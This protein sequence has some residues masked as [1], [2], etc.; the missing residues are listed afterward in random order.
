MPDA[1]QIQAREDDPYAPIILAKGRTRIAALWLDDAPV[2]DF[3]SRQWQ[4]ARLFAAA[5][6]L[7]EA[8][9]AAVDCGI[10][11]KSS[12]RESGAVRHARQ[13]VVADMVRDAITK[14]TGAANRD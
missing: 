13:A 12:A 2:P 7:L 4:Y 8:L 9:Q 11:P 10:I 3:N 1:L 6:E 14:A 5:P